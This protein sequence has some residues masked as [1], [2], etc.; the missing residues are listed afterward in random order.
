MPR[1]RRNCSTCPGRV[2]PDNKSGRCHECLGR[3]HPARS[4]PSYNAPAQLTDS[5]EERANGECTLTKTTSERVRTLAD[6]V[7][8]CEIDLDE[9]DIKWWKCGKWETAMKLETRD[10]TGKILS[11]TPHT[12]QRCL[13]SRPAA[14][15]TVSG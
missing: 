1:K 5:R 4:G 12:E 14:S 3:K 15:C 6:L 9:W 7:R 11:S 8:V 10:A 13:R 2:S